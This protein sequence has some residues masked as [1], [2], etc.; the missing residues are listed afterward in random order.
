MFALTASIQHW[1]GV[2]VGTIQ[3][4]KQIKG[5]QVGKEGVKLSLF[6]DSMIIYVKNLI[7]STKKQN[8]TKN[9]ARTKTQV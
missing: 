2:L 4:G 3:W 8:K 1:I 9:P 6:L 5:I 7:I